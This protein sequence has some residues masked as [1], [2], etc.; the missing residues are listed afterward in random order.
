M[1]L[2]RL[3]VVFVFA[4]LAT[5]PVASPTHAQIRPVFTISNGIAKGV[6]GFH[7]NRSQFTLDGMLGVRKANRSPISALLGIYGGTAFSP[8]SD[9]VALCDYDAASTQLPKCQQEFPAFEYVGLAIGGEARKK[10]VGLALTGGPGAFRSE[11][12]AKSSTILGVLGKA[13]VNFYVG[14]HFQ[15]VVSGSTRH[16]ANYRGSGLFVNGFSI[17]IRVQ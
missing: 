13:D 1:P 5:V 8:G 4:L 6:G 11:Y 3:F 12:L 10:Y 17:G 15:W 2:S 9:Y 16:V 14:E 7:F